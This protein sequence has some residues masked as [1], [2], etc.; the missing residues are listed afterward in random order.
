MQNSFQYGPEC[1]HSQRTV[2]LRITPN[3]HTEPPLQLWKCDL[4]A[5]KNDPSKPKKRFANS[6]AP[7]SFLDMLASMDDPKSL[8]L[9][10]NGGPINDTGEVNVDLSQPKH[11]ATKNLLDSIKVYHI[12]IR[13]FESGP[14]GQEECRI[15]DLSFL[16]SYYDNG[17]YQRSNI[18]GNSGPQW[19][20]SPFGCGTSEGQQQRLGT[21]RH[22]G[23]EFVDIHG[24]PWRKIWKY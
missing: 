2:A 12:N 1:E 20:K 4:R 17:Q 11:E 14:E 15:Q 22:V 18:Q 3:P 8:V 24:E 9:K 16:G 7:I 10:V 13:V 5:E 21:T 23:L 6:D 19:V